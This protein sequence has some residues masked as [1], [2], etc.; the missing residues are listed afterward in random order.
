[1]LPSHKLIASFDIDDGS[2]DGIS[3]Q[4]CFVLGTEWQRFYEML[5]H[6]QPFNQLIHAENVPRLLLLAERSHRFVEH[7]VLPGGWAR[8]VVGNSTD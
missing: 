1:M 8:I 2:L 7:S 5:K 4:T 3:P 6:N